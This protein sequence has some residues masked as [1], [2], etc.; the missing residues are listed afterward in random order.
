[1]KR[2]AI[3][4]TL[5]CS[6]WM[7]CQAAEFKFKLVE[8]KPNMADSFQAALAKDPATAVKAMAK[9]AE[10]EKSGKVEVLGALT[11]DAERG[12]RAKASEDG[13]EIPAAESSGSKEG[14][15][16]EFEWDSEQG[17]SV[18][19][20]A[21]S[22]YFY[23]NGNGED[24]GKLEEMKLTLMWALAPGVPAMVYRSDRDG[25]ARL[26]LA[27]ASVDGAP[28]P[29]D[30]PSLSELT[31]RLYEFDSDK[32]RNGFF[33]KNKDAANVVEELQK[34]AKLRYRATCSTQPGQRWKMG[35]LADVQR[36]GDK[37]VKHGTLL[38]AGQKD[39]NGGAEA[40]VHG[41]FY[42]KA[43]DSVIAKCKFENV[44]VG[45]PSLVRCEGEKPCVLVLQTRAIGLARPV[46]P[47]ND[48]PFGN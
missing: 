39:Y 20:L 26:L 48:D 21:L 29:S 8:M 4:G 3:I 33:F 18:M 23:K 13:A 28:K 37:S 6:N 30:G 41:D 7:P 36:N 16:V 24:A 38:H 9:L 31:A 5:I 45:K 43:A 47:Q 32:A 15:N 10:V 22:V 46:A 35:D 27:K 19:A 2:L 1:M 17:Q 25:M 14:L 40:D 34:E 12:Q 42:L 11:V 44:R